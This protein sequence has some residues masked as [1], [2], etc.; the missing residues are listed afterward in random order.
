MTGAV[1][2]LESEVVEHNNRIERLEVL[3]ESLGKKFD[4]AD[5]DE[6]FSDE[7]VE[8]HE[9]REAIIASEDKINIAMENISAAA[10]SVNKQLARLEGMIEEFA[11]RLSEY[12]MEH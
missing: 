5:D 1:G 7:L 8:R 2:H 3:Y 6:A 9:M 12:E 10:L 11:V 4:R